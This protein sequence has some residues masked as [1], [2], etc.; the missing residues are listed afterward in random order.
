MKAKK[1]IQTIREAL[2]T[3]VDY[4]NHNGWP[5]VM[6]L[7]GSN[8]RAAIMGGGRNESLQNQ[9]KPLIRHRLLCCG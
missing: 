3:L 4:F 9:R 1:A 2:E 6:T 5:R 8:L 7:L